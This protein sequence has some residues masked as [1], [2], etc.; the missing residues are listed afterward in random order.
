MKDAIVFSGQGA[1]YPGMFVDLIESYDCVKQI[2]ED[3]SDIIKI[4]LIDLC[5][6]GT[7]E[8]MAL[9][10]NL[11]PLVL[12]C[13]IAAWEIIKRNVN[14]DFFAGYSLGEYAALYAAGVISFKD[15]M[16]LIVVRAN[17]MQSAVPVG[18][19]GMAAVIFSDADVVDSYFENLDKQVWISN[20]NTNGQYTIA[21]LADDLG[22]VS[23]DLAAKGVIV[24][25]IPVSVPFHC[26]LLLP[27][28]EVIK[29]KL[30]Q[31]TINEP[32]VPIVMNYDG[33]IET[34]IQSIKQKM[35][36]QAFN[37]V[38]WIDT[39]KCLNANGVTRFIECGPGHTLTNFVKRMRMQDVVA[40]NVENSSTLEKVLNP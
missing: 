24:K 31:I 9:T 23:K 33:Q 14:A 12:T 10:E 34:D 25:Q 18:K 32:N 3:A 7:K 2:F 29:E 1:Q 22:Q 19:G 39:L 17:A 8:Q 26:K 5:R 11:Q 20:R 28:A 38:Q 40:L 21:G 36:Y 13:D 27:A 16:E 35:Y 15:V 37:T 6:N 4:D 30:D